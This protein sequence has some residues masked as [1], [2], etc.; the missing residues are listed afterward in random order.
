LIRVGIVG[1]T[2]YTGAELLRLLACHPK[3]RVEIITSRGDAGR[4]VDSLYPNLRGFIDLEFSEPELKAL[5]QCDVVFFATPHGVAQSMMKALYDGGARVIDLSADFRIRDIAVWEKWYGQAHACPELVN[6]AVYG[7]PEHNREKI[8]RAQLVACPGCYP[9]SVQLALMPALKAG[10]VDPTTL[11]ANSASG[12]SG[13]GRSAKV[14]FL[15]AENYDSFKPYGVSGHRHLP[16]IEQGLRD[17]QNADADAAK[18]TFVP[19]LLPTIRGIL[20]TVYA[21]L[22]KSVSGDQVQAIYSDYYRDEI[23]VDVLERGLYPETRFVRGSNMCRLGVE[24]PQGGDV[25]VLMSAIDNLAK[26]ASAQAVQNM[27]LMFGVD[28][29]S[30]LHFPPALP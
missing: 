10:L 14:G 17:M 25:L 5:L 7:L 27:N 15:M 3:A 2:G 28:E 24:V 12:I 11:I 8:K 22:N 9:T 18:I 19:H 30:G 16:E 4:R 6:E 29:D 21:R 26:G 13:A 1:G 23:F 20:S